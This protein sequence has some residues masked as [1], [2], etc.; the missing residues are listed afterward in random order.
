M[1]RTVVCYGDSNTWG[2]TPGSGVRFDEKTRWTGRLQML[3][4]EE[5][6]LKMQVPHPTSALLYA[7]RCDLE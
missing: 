6:H 3:L 5:Y 7:A 4:G 1:S 2:Y